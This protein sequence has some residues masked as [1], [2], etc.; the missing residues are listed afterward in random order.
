MLYATVCTEICDIYNT[1]LV[2]NAKTSTYQKFNPL[3]VSENQTVCFNELG[4]LAKMS[5]PKAVR[6][7]N[8]TIKSIHFRLDQ[9]T[10]VKD[11][12]HLV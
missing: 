10:L 8:I 5:L 12:N 11:K 1:F 3:S 4:I 6:P 7:F 9:N 2:L